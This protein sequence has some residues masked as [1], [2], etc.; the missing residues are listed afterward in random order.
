MIKAAFFDVDGTLYS[1]NIHGVPES[2]I[3]ALEELRKNGIQVFLATG[4]HFTEIEDLKMDHIPFDGYVMLTGQL[5][6]DGEKNIIFGNAIKPESAKFL[7]DAFETKELPLMMV[8]KDCLYVNMTNEV[9]E[10]AQA[11]ISSPVPPIGEYTGEPIYQM[12]SYGGKDLEELLA[13]KVPECI[14]TRW[15]PF[16]V[17][18][19]SKNGGKVIGIEKV[20]EHYGFTKE[21]TIAFGDGENDLEMLAFAGIGVAMGNADEE[22]KEVADYVTTDI[23]D[24][25]IWNAC[26]HFHLI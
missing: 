9:V 23:D 7:F 13:E 6:T 10:E 14:V 20:L 25:G 12:V 22:V 3:R 26:K 8:E 19:I 15:S 5:C 1:H 24:D 2:S 11:G 16:G 18:I 21:E 17:D 4:R